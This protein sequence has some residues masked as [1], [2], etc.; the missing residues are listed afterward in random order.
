MNQN[1]PDLKKNMDQEVLGAELVQ[2]DKENCWLTLDEKIK[3]QNASESKY[4][5]LSYG[6]EALPY[7]M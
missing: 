3:Q 7:W 4:I 5:F 6:G 2:S 1:D